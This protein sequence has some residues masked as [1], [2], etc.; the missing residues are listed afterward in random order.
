MC[1]YF[2]CCYLVQA[3]AAAR[4]I[5]TVCQTKGC[6]ATLDG[7]ALLREFRQQSLAGITGVACST[8][9][10]ILALLLRQQLSLLCA[11]WCVL[12]SGD[13]AIG[14]MSYRGVGSGLANMQLTHAGLEY[15]LVL[16]HCLC[17]VPQACCAPSSAC[18]RFVQVGDW[19]P[20]KGILFL[21]ASDIEW[22]TP[23]NKRPDAGM[24]LVRCP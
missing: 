4:A 7:P 19:D 10:C 8:V 24:L 16:L 23:N 12:C 1:V 21:N 15:A 13:I 2:L 9:P 6:N 20:V 14:D 22:Y 11:A 17:A 5:G 18:A 3:L